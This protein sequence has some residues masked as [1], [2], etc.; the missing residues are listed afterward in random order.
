[1]PPEED[2]LVRSKLVVVAKSLYPHPQLS[3][4]IPVYDWNKDIAD[5]E[6][7]KQ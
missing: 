6:H 2:P 1:M 7:Q 4:C 3:D 5:D